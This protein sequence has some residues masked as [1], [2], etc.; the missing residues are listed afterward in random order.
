MPQILGFGFSVYARRG[1]DAV[2]RFMFRRVWENIG[3]SLGF[4]GCIR[5]MAVG[6]RRL[7]LASAA[8][9][10]AV[11]QCGGDP[12]SAQPCRHGGVCHS[13]NAL[14]AFKCECPLNYTGTSALPP[15]CPPSS[16]P[17]PRADPREG[18]SAAGRLL[19]S[20][21]FSLYCLP[22]PFS[23]YQVWIRSSAT[24]ILLRNAMAS[25]KPRY[26]ASELP[27]I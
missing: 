15:S 6:Q 21:Q 20:R 24:Y 4:T 19:G 27:H 25:R 5:R 23:K 12:C 2:N 22:T 11:G 3:T 9:S 26:A 18:R 8:G 10:S 17:L 16:R 14:N 13:L 1:A 7:D